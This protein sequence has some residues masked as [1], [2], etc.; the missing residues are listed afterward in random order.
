MEREAGRKRDEG[1]RGG[2]EGGRY[3]EEEM[4]ISDAATDRRSAHANYV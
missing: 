4:R 1:R 2:R 3:R